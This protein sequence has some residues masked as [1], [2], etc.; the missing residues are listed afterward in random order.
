MKEIGIYRRPVE[1][2]FYG[3]D[4]DRKDLITRQVQHYYILSQPTE[5]EVVI[6]STQVLD[7]DE[8]QLDFLQ[9]EGE[10]LRLDYM[11]KKVEKEKE[12]QESLGKPQ[13]QTPAFRTPALGVRGSILDIKA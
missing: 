10:K 2:F 11:S 5:D 3:R 9:A 7:D 1:D 13:E 12:A 4:I 8:Q 6:S